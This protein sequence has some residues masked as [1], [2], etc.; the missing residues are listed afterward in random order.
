MNTYTSDYSQGKI[1][2]IICNITGDQY[3][4]STK[5]IYLSRR[6][7]KHRTNLNE[8]DRGSKRGKVTVYEILRRGDYQII[9]VETY[10]CKSKYELESRERYYI[11]NN[12]CVNKTIPTRTAKEYRV[13]NFEAISRKEKEYRVKNRKQLREKANKQVICEKCGKNS[14]Y[15]HLKRHQSS[16]NC[17]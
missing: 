14:T 11:E 13:A 16:R 8:F 7:A 4:G 17:S 6:L 2:R 12:D 3:Y 1:Y 10:P 15:N 5:E 9:L